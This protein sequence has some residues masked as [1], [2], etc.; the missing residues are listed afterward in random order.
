MRSY[1]LLLKNLFLRNFHLKLISVLLALLLWITING[2]PKSE[3]GFRAPL[4]YRNSPDGIE[5][6]GEL[7]NSVDVRVSASSSVVKQ[8]DAG[9]ISVVIDLSDW[10]LGERTY[11]ITSANIRIP[12]GIKITKITPN[13]VRLRFEP[14]RHKTVD[15]RPRILGKIAPGYRLSAVSCQPATV[16]IEGPEAHLATIFFV[17]TD[18]IDLTDRTESF[19]PKVHL[20]VDDP[21]VRFSR[22][23]QTNV[24]IVIV[25]M[26]NGEKDDKG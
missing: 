20:Y 10:S 11:S 24:E 8:L 3:V 12:F 15:I 16:A 5:V 4:E 26:L 17:S 22:E 23:H 2:E 9:D 21:L 19:K 18:S 6:L 7:A 13:K 25:P 1:L 14:T